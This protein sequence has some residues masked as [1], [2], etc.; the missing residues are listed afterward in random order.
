MTVQRWGAQGTGASPGDLPVALDARR[1]SG[2]EREPIVPWRPLTGWAVR[3]LRRS[4][5]LLAA[6]A[7][8]YLVA[9]VATFSTAYPDGVGT[10]QFAVL[11]DNP[12]VRMLQGPPQGLG[13]AAGFAVWDAGWVLEIIVGTWAVLVVSR[14]LRGDEDTGRTELLLVGPVRARVLTLVTLV[15]ATAA[16][17]VLAVTATGA[18]VLS[19]G[20]AAP[21]ALFGVGLSGFVATFVGVGAVT[22]QLLDVR[23]RAAGLAAAVLGTC[24]AVRMAANSA[25]DRAWLGWLSPFGWVDRL[26]PYGQTDPVA[27]LPLLLVPIALSVLAIALRGRRDTGGALVPT[28]DRRRPRHRGLGGSTSFAWRSN[29]GVLVGWV[30]GLSAYGFVIGSLFSV[31]TDFLGRDASYRQVMS[32]LGLDVALT[33]DGLLGTM[34]VTL[35][36]GFAVYACWRVGAVRAEE[37]SGRL[38]NLLARRVSRVSWLTGHVLVTVAASG[39]LTVV[40]GLSL[41]AGAQAS[42]SGRVPLGTVMSSVLN[43]GSV[44][45]LVTGAAVLVFAVVPRLTVVLPVGAT[46]A[47]YLLAL[48]GPALSWP[49]WVTDLSPYAHLAYVPAEPFEARSAVVMVLIGITAAVGGVGVFVRRDTVGD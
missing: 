12:A 8:A 14:L 41:W 36:V 13:G 28:T 32:D 18:L 26:Q 4:T 45:V 17:L 43:T 48:L 3:Q 2:E 30:V 34:S 24:F 25:D 7:A 39:L 31:V 16:A 21:A 40:T 23:R 9:E 20:E 29:Q 37:E 46:V 27:L 1:P 38:G 10:E 44:V 15:V 22:S 19:G 5:A 42:G 11:L 47:G 49:T 35:S 6:S 33:V